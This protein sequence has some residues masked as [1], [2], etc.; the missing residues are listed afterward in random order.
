MH[1]ASDPHLTSLGRADEQPNHS[2]ISGGLG[3]SEVLV[4]SFDTVRGGF[5][6][7]NAHKNGFS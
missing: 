6:T 7:H 2:V 1:H 3:W 5:V 4:W